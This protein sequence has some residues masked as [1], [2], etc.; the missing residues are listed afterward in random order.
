[1]NQGRTATGMATPLI[2]AK[3]K[4]VAST[5]KFGSRSTRH[6]DATR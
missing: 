3:A 5:K 2:M 1:M 6:A 4:F